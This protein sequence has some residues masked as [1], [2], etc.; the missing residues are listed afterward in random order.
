MAKPKLLIVEDD[1]GLCSQYRWAF[2]D[3][4]VQLAHNRS[5]AVGM[6][7]KDNPPVAIMDLGLP[8]DPDGVSEGFATL[9]EVQRIS[10][11]TKVIVVTGNGE[12]KVALKA[13]A[14]GAYDFCE[15]PVEL[16]VLRT[17]IGRGLNLHRLEEENRRLAAMP[18]RSPIER[19]V[20]GHPAMLKVCRDVEKLATTNVPVLLL[21]DSGTGKEALAQALHQLG[22]RAKQPFIAINCGAIPENLLESELFGHERGAFTGAVK[23]TI[24]KIESAHKGTL[25]LDE[26]GDLPHPLQVKLLRFLQDQIVERIGGRQ[27]IQVGVRIVSATNAMLEEQVTKGTFRGDLFYRMNAVTIRIPPLRDRG[28][29]IVLLANY[30]LNRFNQEFGRNI[31]GF[32]EPATLAMNAHSWPGNVR[33]LENRMKRAVVMAERRMIDASDLE[34]APASDAIPDL[35]LRNA[36]LRAEREVIQIALARSNYTLSVAARLLGV[37]RPTLYGLMEQHGIEAEPARGAETGID[38]AADVTGTTL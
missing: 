28:S 17:I 23:Q 10:P 18:T 24:G 9:E 30:F 14:S 35:D 20:T 8:P 25:F 3:C 12:R 26:I 4:D 6:V 19:I 34:L 33:E 7:K 13:V 37:S 27:K 22:P 11:Q 21:G 36:R 15:K 29:D 38:F 31:R 5:Q 1:E 16:D 2:P 32:T